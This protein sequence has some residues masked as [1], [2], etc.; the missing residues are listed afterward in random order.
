MINTSDIKLGFGSLPPTGD[1]QEDI[2]MSLIHPGSNEIVEDLVQVLQLLLKQSREP[3]RLNMNLGKEGGLAVTRACFAV[4][5]K[6]SG[7]SNK[8]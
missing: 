8:L 7:L 1:E 4:I 5:V 6:L 2:H 3:I